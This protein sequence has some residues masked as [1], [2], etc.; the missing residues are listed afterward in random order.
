MRSGPTSLQARKRTEQRGIEGVP[1]TWRRC[2]RRRERILTCRRDVAVSLD[3]DVPRLDDLRPL[4]DLFADEPPERL[5]RGVRGL[6]AIGA[7][8]RLNLR[9]LEYARD[10]LIE[11]ARRSPARVPPGA[12][13]PNQLATSYPG[14]ASAIAG[15]S[16]STGDRFSVVTA[17]PR[18][19]PALI[20]GVIA[21]G[22]LMKNWMWPP[23]RSAS[24]GVSP[25]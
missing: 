7:Q 16:G 4:G 1:A 14:T 21:S 15:K 3:L 18:I 9:L 22:E 6:D 11:A 13:M 25:L 2:D 23:S 17:S 20:C 19:F 24:A 8:P 5:G 10:R 12:H